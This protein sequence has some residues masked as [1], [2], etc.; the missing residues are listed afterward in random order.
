L[1]LL[2]LLILVPIVLGK[3]LARSLPDQLRT[4]TVGAIVAVVGAALAL[5]GFASVN[6]TTSK[7]AA[8]F[9]T[10]DTAGIASIGVGAL[11]LV[12]GFVVILSN[13][14]PSP[15]SQVPSAKKCPYCAES[16]QV[17]AK[18]CRYCGKDL[19]SKSG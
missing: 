19:E 14:T 9:G 8:R 11:L 4:I 7:V 15:K 16:I 18:L 6:S 5:Y 2:V 10:L 13:R 17:E 12:V 1:I 3:V